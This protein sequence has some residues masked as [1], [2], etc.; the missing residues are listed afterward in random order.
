MEDCLWWGS[1]HLQKNGKETLWK[2]KERISDS[3]IT[4]ESR[5]PRLNS[6]TKTFPNPMTNSANKAVRYSRRIVTSNSGTLA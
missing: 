5:S 3:E 1:S 2:P 6:R 4:Q